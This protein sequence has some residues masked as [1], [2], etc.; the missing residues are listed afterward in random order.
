MECYGDVAR[1]DI[2]RQRDN[3]EV[4]TEG[5]GVSFSPVHQRDQGWRKSRLCPLGINTSDR[6]TFFQAQISDDL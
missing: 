4:F 5:R 3:T 6:E 1:L 2:T